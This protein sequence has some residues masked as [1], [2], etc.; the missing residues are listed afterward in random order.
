M[1]AFNICG[2]KA[3]QAGHLNHRVQTMQTLFNKV[4]LQNVF[5]ILFF[6]TIYT[7]LQHIHVSYIQLAASEINKRTKPGGELREQTLCTCNSIGTPRTQCRFLMKVKHFIT[8]I[9]PPVNFRT[10]ASGISFNN[11]EIRPGL[12]NNL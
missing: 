6:N 3:S 9:Y 12:M 4:K 7:V 5:R 8:Y 11:C 10:I 2:G 1:S